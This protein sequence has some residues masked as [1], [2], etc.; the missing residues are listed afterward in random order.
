MTDTRDVIFFTGFPGFL[1]S[2]LL[3]RVL[4][5]AP[6][7]V[8]VCLVQ[9]K[10]AELATRRLTEIGATHP[11]VV[12][13]ARIIEGDI[14]APE[15]G[16][17]DARAL[18]A[19]IV[20]I[21]HLAAVYDLSVGRDLAMRVNVE[22]TRHMLAF[23]QRCPRL[24]RFQYVSTCYVSGRYPGVFREDMLEESQ[25]FNNHYEETK[26]LAE[27]EVQRAARAGLPT[28]IYRPAVVVGDATTG[29]T[30]KY[31]GPYFAMQWLLRQPSVA[32]M[33]V[34]G[35]TRR[36]RFNSV[37]RDFVVG[38][39]AYLSGRPETVGRVYQLADPEAP[40]VEEMLRD[41]AHVTHK[42]VIRIPLPLRL[43]KTMIRRVPGVY[44]LLRIPASAIDY[45]VLPTTYDTEHTERD[46][47]GSGI[48]CPPFR[49]YA[50]RLVAFMRAH[51]DLGA[52]AMA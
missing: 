20:E 14:T 51:P 19:R 11:D 12:D 21:F 4:A 49:E 35:D 37:P 10:F 15:L 40:T 18:E 16:L 33:P 48:R 45:F 28:T 43:A 44:R 22:G 8:A 25:A 31:D 47:R 30:Q 17:G 29:V 36:T 9:S 2:E 32:L 50:D 5:R 1:G 46:L 6:E 23:A 42:T 39:I 41:I 13:R 27:V 7:A 34:V 24:R 38:A 26:Y 52:K 3:P